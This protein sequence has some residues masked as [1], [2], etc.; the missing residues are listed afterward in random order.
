MADA[1]GRTLWRLGVTRRHLLE[2]VPAAQTA[3]GPRLDLLGFVRRMAGAIAIGAA[4]AI[5][6]LTSRHGSWPLALPFAALWVASPAVARFVSLSPGAASQL[7]MA[8]TDVQALRR[9]G[10]PHLAVLRD[11]RHVGGQRAAARQFSG[12]SGACGRSSDLADQYRPLSSFRRLRARF[13]L[14]R[15]RPG[16]RSARGDARDDERHATLSRTF[17]QL[18]RHARSSP[19]RPE[20]R[21]HRRQRQS[22]GASHRARQCVPGMG[23][24]SL[25]ARRGDSMASPTRSEITRAECARLRD[26]RQTQ[27]V[28][29]HQ[30]DD[31]LA[32]VAIGMRQASLS[33]DDCQAQ[34]RRS[35]PQCRDHGRHCRRAR[36]SNAATAAVRICC[37]GRER[38]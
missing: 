28:T 6:A 32:A 33:Q 5:V 22:G 35:L 15:N 14:D 4:A 2:W 8:Q 9:T 25:R 11:F 23:R 16:D 37:F 34:T 29:L 30:L 24:P 3:I 13:R 1:I 18:V 36:R 26:G 7:P 10:A 21:V 12:Q 20:I 19:A 31:A 17:L 38:S 27:T